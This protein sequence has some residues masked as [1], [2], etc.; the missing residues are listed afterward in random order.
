[1]IIQNFVEIDQC[2][3][4][5]VLVPLLYEKLMIKKKNR[6]KRKVGSRFNKEIFNAEILSISEAFKV[7]EQKTRKIQQPWMINV[8]SNS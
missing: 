1:M 8:F 5:W 7:A 4:A 3:K 2:Y 6:H